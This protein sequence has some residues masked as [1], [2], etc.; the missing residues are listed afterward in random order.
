MFNMQVY[1][2]TKHYGKSEWVDFVRDLVCANDRIQMK[3]HL[4]TGCLECGNTAS[5]LAKVA[6]E[7]AQDARYEPPEH[8]LQYARLVHRLQHPEVVWEL[9]RTI[10]K[11]IFDSFRGPLPVGVRSQQQMVRQV[12]Y[13]AGTYFLDFRLEHNPGSEEMD[14]LGQI[15]NR[16]IPD[17]GV[18]SVTVL[19]ISGKSVVSKALTNKFGE[20]QMKYKPAHSLRLVAP[21]PEANGEIEVPL[22]GILSRFE[23]QT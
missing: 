11:L 2:K 12:L 6:F 7:A 22:G 21:V 20:F 1:K 4:E 3:H 19:L 15:T 18:A 13:Q 10:A 17:T 14:M 8:A 9:P 16:D 23:E 5:L